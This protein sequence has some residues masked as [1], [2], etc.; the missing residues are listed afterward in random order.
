MRLFIAAY[1]PADVERHLAEMTGSLNVRQPMPEGR[2]LR[3][4]PVE[5][6][7]MT[8]AFIGEVEDAKQEAAVGALH[9]LPELVPEVRIAGGGRFG[10]GKFTTLFAKV[11][12]DVAPLGDAV[13]AALRKRRVPFDHR[14]LQPHVTIARPSDR[15]PEDELMADLEALNAYRGP[16]WRVG[17]VRLMKSEL[18]PKPH[19][20]ALA[21]TRDT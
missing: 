9:A 16:L 18:G 4:V 20:T 12:G 10:R 14:P 6:W 13:R 7:H 11:D 5:Q 8:L 15:L 19:Y 3:V 1:L 17:D 2:S 21:T